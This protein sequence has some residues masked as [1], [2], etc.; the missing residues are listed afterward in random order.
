MLNNSFKGGVMG[1]WKG[2]WVC[3]GVVALV[4]V[5]LFFLGIFGETGA[6]VDKEFGPQAA[7]EKYTWF[8][9][10]AAGIKKMDADIHLFE[11]KVGDIDKQYAAYGQDK[12]K[13]RP[14][15]TIQYNQAK[16]TARSDLMAVVS[17]RNNLAKDFNAASQKF[18]WSLF[19]TRKDLPSQY[20][21][22]YTSPVN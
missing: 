19:N 15:I 18:N 21:E 8:V 14:D 20:I 7:M 13:W 16:E 22:Q 6:V 4:M 11:Q 5:T 1:F 17:Q 12:T 3:V 9:D 10:Q 2:F